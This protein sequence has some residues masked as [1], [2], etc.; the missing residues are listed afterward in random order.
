MVANVQPV[1]GK[2]PLQGLAQISTANANRD[3][4]GTIAD[5]CTAGSDGAYIERVEVKAT[6]TTTAGM[7]RLY[8][9]DGTNTRLIDEVAVAA[10]TPSATVAAFQGAFALVAAAKPWFLPPNWKLRV[11]TEKGETFNVRAVGSQLS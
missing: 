6:V 10:I 3:G 11:S 2:T 9:S 1:F 4:T 5:L 8:E 7:I